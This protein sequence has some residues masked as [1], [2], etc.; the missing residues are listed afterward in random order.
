Q[1]LILTGESVTTNFTRRAFLGL[2]A[3]SAAG[4]LTGVAGAT[5]SVAGATGSA[6]GSTAR[7]R[8]GPLDW[9]RLSRHLDGDLILPSDWFY[10][11]ARQ[12]SLG[13]F[14]STSP[15]AIAY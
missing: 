14:D 4:V 6:A 13:Q 7:R 5:G 8:G 12:Q 3:A 2:A 11:Q 9:Q 15:M 1:L 10:G